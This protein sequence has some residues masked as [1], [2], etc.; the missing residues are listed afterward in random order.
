MNSAKNERGPMSA[1]ESKVNVPSKE[2][3]FV[4]FSAAITPALHAADPAKQLYDDDDDDNNNNNKTQSTVPFKWIC[5][6]SSSSSF[7]LQ[8]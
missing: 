1:C 8:P 7:A 4:C 3:V 6:L 2:T 5:L